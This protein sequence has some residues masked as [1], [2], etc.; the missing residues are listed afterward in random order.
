MFMNSQVKKVLDGYTKTIPAKDG[1]KEYGNA[2]KFYD[3]KVITETSKGGKKTTT[4]VTANEAGRYVKFIP[5]VYFSEIIAELNDNDR[6]QMI[7]KLQNKLTGIKMAGYGWADYVLEDLRTIKR[8]LE[9]QYSEV[10]VT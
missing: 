5:T 9:S 8:S 1:M 3:C 4:I 6:A 10:S 2:L 7:T